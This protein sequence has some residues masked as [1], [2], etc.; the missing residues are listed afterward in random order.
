MLT[1]SKWINIICSLIIGLV[2]GLAFLFVSLLASGA[3]SIRKPTITVYTDSNRKL[4]D[5]SPLTDRGWDMEGFLK[6]GHQASMIYRSERT[7]AGTSEN[8]MELVIIDEMGM[9]VTASYDIQYQYGTLTVEPRRLLIIGDTNGLQN[10]VLD[11]AG[12][13]ISES[14]DGLIAGHREQISFQNGLADIKI[15][16]SEGK[17]YTRNYFIILQLD[18]NTTFPENGAP[19]VAIYKVYSDVSDTV[20]LKTRSYGD[21]L[22]KE[23]WKPAPQYTNLINGK[24]AAAYL[25]GFALAENNAPATMITVE[26]LCGYYALPY[27]M[28][29]AGEYQI[30]TDETVYSGNTS[31]PYTVQYYRYADG[32]PA[33]T[34]AYGDFEQE[35]RTF[36]YDN[37]LNLD[38]T[39][40]MYMEQLIVKQ[41]FSASDPDIIKKVAS[42]IQNAAVYNTEYP[43]SLETEENVAIAFLEQYKEG[44]C[45]HYSISAT[46][47][48]RALG[49][50]ARYCV[51]ALAF[52]EAGRWTEVPSNQAHAWVEVYR[53]GIGWIFVEVTGGGVSEGGGQGE[54]PDDLKKFTVKP[55]TVRYRYDGKTHT[56]DGKVSGLEALTAQGF[57]YS[58]VIDGQRLQAGK[59]VTEIRELKIL[60]PD[61]N[62]VT[63]QYELTFDTGI[64]HIYYE[65]FDFQSSAAEKNYDGKPLSVKPSIQYD[66]SRLNRYQ[67]RAGIVIPEDIPVNIGTHLN[68]FEVKLYDKNDGNDVTDLYWANATYGKLVI[69]PLT[70]TIKAGD[71]QKAYDGTELTCREYTIIQGALFEG[72]S[73]DNVV[74]SGSQTTVGRSD[75]EIIS[76]LILDENGNDITKNYS[77]TLVT[78][79]LRVT[80]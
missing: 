27:Y 23:S 29:E 54:Q 80:R 69:H 14:C 62:D 55:S 10:G 33:L 18:G 63:D 49:I 6:D 59:T 11:P 24:Y 45:R 72:H 35:Y 48:F 79:K 75:N 4:Y 13:Q 44:V 16:D 74:F 3:L 21:Y 39:S 12:Y 25:P 28:S 42:F 41:G 50:P 2:F 36:V 61:G 65:K 1:K 70:L 46:L 71:A 31:E 5:G 73:I 57:K 17:E 22:G 40:R 64:L 26:S 8:I 7:E 9:D 77:I 51:G 60:D 37:Y 30:Q 52:T 78:G 32:T 67:L 68:R 66:P 34:G 15:T 58:A 76:V 47:L 38:T 19:N 20:Y 53:D 56:S 43:K